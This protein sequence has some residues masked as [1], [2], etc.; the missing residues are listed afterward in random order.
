M[1]NSLFV[2]A[3]ITASTSGIVDEGFISTGIKLFESVDRPRKVERNTFDTITQDYKSVIIVW[4]SIFNPT[5]IFN[6]YRQ[7]QFQRQNT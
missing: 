6:G 2:K 7:L 1:V 4:T 3:S 5:I